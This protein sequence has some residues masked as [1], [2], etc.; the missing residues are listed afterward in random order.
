LHFYRKNK[1][2][3][4]RDVARISS[5]VCGRGKRGRLHG[6]GVEFAK[7]LV[8]SISRIEDG[9]HEEKDGRS[10]CWK[11][12]RNF[13]PLAYGKQA[14]ATLSSLLLRQARFFHFA[15]YLIPLVLLLLLSLLLLFLFS[16][17]SSGSHA[18]FANASQRNLLAV[19]Q[20]IEFSEQKRFFLGSTPDSVSFSILLFPL[21]PPKFISRRSFP[22]LFI[23]TLELT[24]NSSRRPS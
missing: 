18:A 2:G 23:S 5:A 10:D 12:E 17:L 21:Y 24:G 16:L 4:T 3:R 7:A 13:Q 15:L 1:L 6:D 19:L 8:L 11:Y 22:C 14:Q 9:R 20:R